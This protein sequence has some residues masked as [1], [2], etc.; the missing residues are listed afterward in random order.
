MMFKYS[1]RHPPFMIPG[2]VDARPEWRETGKKQWANET[3]KGS[4]I[5]DK[6]VM[7][8]CGMT[9]GEF[10]MQLAVTQYERRINRQS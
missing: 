9:F 4:I 1:R 10:S 3:K 5:T 2:E 6:H 7:P 8:S